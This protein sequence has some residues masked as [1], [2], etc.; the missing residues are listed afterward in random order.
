MIVLRVYYPI[1]EQI[2]NMYKLLIFS[3]I[4][5]FSCTSKKEHAKLTFL[6]KGNES[7]E[8]GNLDQAI[9]YYNEAILADSTFVDAYLNNA[10]VFETKG[11]YYEAIAMYDAI[12]GMDPQNDNALFK[13][14]NLYLDV[15]QYYRSLDDLNALSKTWKDSSILYFSKGL[16]N[17][18]LEK[19]TEAIIDFKRAVSLEP[20]NPKA[21]INIGNVFYHTHQLDSAEYYL[22]QGLILDAAEA[23]GYNTL[24]LIA[25]ARQDY[26][27][28]LDQIDKALALAE[29]N[30][31]YLNNKG[32]VY[33]KMDK[34]DSAEYL[35]NTSLK[36]DPYN[37]WVYR[38]KG[39]LELKKNNLT[40][41]V[42]LLA[43]AY[44][45]DK[46]I[47]H[48]AIDLAD[49]Y[50]QSG[51]TSKACEIIKSVDGDEALPLQSIYCNI[52]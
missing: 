31:W 3:V 50:Y 28:S 29:N 38:N 51:D 35:I 49:A 47:H 40:K 26:Q 46:S 36:S 7:F 39:L 17:T 37:A 44:K 21:I 4:I 45:M 9:F 6:I 23:N 12:I 1:F 14:A 22:K 16:V 11:M 15:N 34:L 2:F 30:A 19:Y 18:R 13:R 5:L 25:I 41:A 32:Y 10:L 52:Q 24:S 20:N 27:Q 33:L 42:K 48:L 8:E 43:K